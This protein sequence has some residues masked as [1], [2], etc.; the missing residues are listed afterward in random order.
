MFW[1]VPLTLDL[2]SASGG[3]NL[4]GATGHRLDELLHPADD[5]VGRGAG[6]GAQ[7][8]AGLAPDQQLQRLLELPLV[9]AAMSIRFCCSSLPT[10]TA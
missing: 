5:L 1:I 8:V 6:M 10:V 4:L 9:A 7:Q 2:V 3:L